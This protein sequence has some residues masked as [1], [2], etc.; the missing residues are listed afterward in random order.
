MAWTVTAEV[1]R[2]EEAAEWFMNRAVITRDEALRLTL[3]VRQRAFW[4]GGGLQLTQIQRVFDEISKAIESGEPFEEWRE[5]VR[6]TLRSDAHAETVFRN[7][8]Q[9]AYSAGRWRQMNDPELLR[10]RPY[11]MFDAVL[12][13]RTTEICRP[14]DSTI[15]PADHEF[16]RTHVPPLHHRCRSGIRSLRKSAAEERGITNV[17]PVIEPDEGF[18]LAPGAQPVWKPD[19][20]KHDPALRKELDKKDAK[21]PRKRKAKDPPPTHDPRYWEERLREQYG[22]A[23]P[24]IA[25]GRAMYE[26]GLDRSGREIATELERLRDAGVPGLTGAKFTDISKLK[27]RRLRGTA[28]GSHEELRGYIALAE[29][30]LSIERGTFPVLSGTGRLNKGTE[31]TREAALFYRQLLDKSSRRPSSWTLV[32]D[33]APRAFVDDFRKTVALR[34]GRNAP[35]AIHELAHALETENVGTLTRSRAFLKARTR[36]ER[37]RL[38]N[39][40]LPGH[41]YSWNEFA[42]EDKFFD[43]YVGKDYGERATEVTSMGYQKLAEPLGID[44]LSKRDWEML[45]FLLG[46]LAGR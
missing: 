23:A 25:W 8:V 40:L 34:D 20:A 2:F 5:R 6:G 9:R 11:F 39:D 4:I 30:S 29:H 26:R 18:G 12:D 33:S 3:D 41:G 17:P 38:L 22:A 37:L 32:S 44:Y 15:L 13:S 28:V 31:G 46:Q 42:W 24:S 43:A 27:N 1:G 7:A 14:L 19:P 16:W 45:Q 36:G 35:V 21:A 10:A